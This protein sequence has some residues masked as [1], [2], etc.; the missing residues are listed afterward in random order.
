MNLYVLVDIKIIYQMIYSKGFLKFEIKK[1]K[2]LS[3]L[4]RQLFSLQDIVKMFIILKIKAKNW[5]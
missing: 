5:D 4:T 1:I 2:L 3:G